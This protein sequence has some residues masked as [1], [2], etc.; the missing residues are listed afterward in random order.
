MIKSDKW[1]PKFLYYLLRHISSL[2]RNYLDYYHLF[3]IN[4]KLQ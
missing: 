3:K 2:I 1:P 4:Y